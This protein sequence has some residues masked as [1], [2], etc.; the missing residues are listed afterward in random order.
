L[1]SA[2]SFTFGRSL[3]KNRV[4][5]LHQALQHAEH[6][7]RDLH[8]YLKAEQ[9][10]RNRLVDLQDARAADDARFN[11]LHDISDRMLGLVA[12]CRAAYEVEPDGWRR[13]QH[14]VA[15]AAYSRASDDIA[16]YAN[17]KVLLLQELRVERRAVRAALGRAVRRR[18]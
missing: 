8:H 15:V 14:T 16:V 18:V 2:G 7:Y 5:E 10:L 17:R 3:P 1:H 6:R 9:T 13:E 12:E 4:V 11:A